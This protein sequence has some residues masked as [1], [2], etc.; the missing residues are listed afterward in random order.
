M[1]SQL[2]TR[3]R[4]SLTLTSLLSGLGLSTGALA[5]SSVSGPGGDE[6]SRVEEAIHQEVTLKANRKR[7][8][9]A[10]TETDQFRKVTGVEGTKISREV[11][12]AFTLF[13]GAIEGR[14]VELVPAARIVQA[15]RASGWE[16][17]KYSIAR[18]ELKDEGTG[19]RIVFEHTGFPKGQADHLAS[20]WKEHYWDSLTRYFGG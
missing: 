15:W 18:F 12:G 19:T 4:F 11:G 2:L 3:R 5:S 7:V 16:N 17:G 6:I 1:N 13:G 10:L 8:Y 20:G 14:H 9:E